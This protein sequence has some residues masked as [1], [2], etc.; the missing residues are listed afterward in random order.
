VIEV[1]LKIL[2]PNTLPIRNVQIFRSSFHDPLIISH[3]ASLSGTLAHPMPKETTFLHEN[4]L[5]SH[6]AWKAAISDGVSSETSGCVSL[7]M[8]DP[9]RIVAAKSKCVTKFMGQ[10]PHHL[11]IIT[12]LIDR[13]GLF[14]AFYDIL[15]FTEFFI[16]N[17]DTCK[18]GRP[19]LCESL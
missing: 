8:T 18:V 13:D 15:A 4:H 3:L 9:G 6:R 2:K 16:I 1:R 12:K 19:N 7:C 17:F 14:A 10:Y 5:P 11:I